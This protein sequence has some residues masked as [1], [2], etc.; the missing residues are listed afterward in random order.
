VYNSSFLL[1]N[2][3]V[4]LTFMKN[5]VKTNLFLISWELNGRDRLNK[6]AK[7]L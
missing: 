4:Y 5:V 1:S 3:L 6:V 2:S 7:V